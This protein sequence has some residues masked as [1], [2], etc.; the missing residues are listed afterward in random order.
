M[1]LLIAI[2]SSFRDV[3]VSA[4]LTA[5]GEVGLTGEIRTVT[6]LEQRLK[7]V[8][9]LGFDTSII[10]RHGTEKIS[11][12]EGLTLYRVRNI[13]EAIEIAL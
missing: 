13:R 10:P 6:S 12:P 9:R 1:P 5:I 8:R 7:E 4:S 3:P 11:A 2:A